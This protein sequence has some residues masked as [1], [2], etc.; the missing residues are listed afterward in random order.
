M[1]IPKKLLKMNRLKR[2]RLNFVAT[3]VS[4]ILFAAKTFDRAVWISNF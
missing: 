3:F 1:D 4:A 2:Y